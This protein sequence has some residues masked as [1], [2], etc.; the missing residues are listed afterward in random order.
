MSS[1][2]EPSVP[3]ADGYIE[4]V[5]SGYSLQV[6]TQWRQTSNEQFH[7]LFL[8]PEQKDFSPNLGVSLEPT[9]AETTITE[10]AA[11]GQR[12]QAQAYD[13]YQIISEE[14]LQVS[15]EPAVKRIYSWSDAESGLD[16]TQ[17]QLYV[18]R[19]DTLFIITGTSLTEAFE[20]YGPVFDYMIST[21]QLR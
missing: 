21:F 13:G 12:Y 10:I 20:A 7:A 16:I 6:P 17:T 18:K 11:A 4:F 3:V 19:D 1:G 5:G 15:G 14:E 2:G 9:L 8:G